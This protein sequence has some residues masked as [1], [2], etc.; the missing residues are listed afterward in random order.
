MEFPI[1]QVADHQPGGCFLCGNHVGPFIDAQIEE[2]KILTPEGQERIAQARVYFC[3]GDADRPGTGRPQ[4]RAGLPA[5]LR[6]EAV[7]LSFRAVVFQ[8]RIAGRSGARCEA[9]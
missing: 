9:R 1:V 4:V 7:P 3:I 5:P 8:L 2:I 6:L